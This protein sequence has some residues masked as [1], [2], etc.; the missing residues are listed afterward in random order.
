MIMA[1]RDLRGAK[2]DLIA[3]EAICAYA[4]ADRGRAR[5]GDGEPLHARRL[6]APEE[7]DRVEFAR[8]RLN[9]GARAPLEREV[10]LHRHLLDIGAFADHHTPGRGVVHRRLDR[11]VVRLAALALARRVGHAVVV[12]I[13]RTA[14]CR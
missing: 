8:R 11:A 12:Y 3:Y 10:A 1:D 2:G 13:H 5:A 7:D 6:R 9:H 4:R 14:T